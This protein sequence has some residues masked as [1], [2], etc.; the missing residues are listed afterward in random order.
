MNAADAR[1]AG[2]NSASDM[3]QQEQIHLQNMMEQQ[4]QAQQ[5]QSNILKKQ[6]ETQD[7]II[8]NIK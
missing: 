7:S 4:N 1:N 6:S 5:M 2:M 8:N 3:R